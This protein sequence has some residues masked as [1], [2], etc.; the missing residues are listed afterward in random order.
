MMGRTPTVHSDPHVEPCPR[1]QQLRDDVK[2]DQSGRVPSL[3]RPRKGDLE[4]AAA[5]HTFQPSGEYVG[6]GQTKERCD[7]CGLVQQGEGTHHD[8]T[9]PARTPAAPSAD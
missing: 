4:A 1:C 3:V 7:L 8:V 2:S 9:P 6:L 5:R